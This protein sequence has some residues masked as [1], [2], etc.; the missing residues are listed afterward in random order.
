MFCILTIRIIDFVFSKGDGICQIECYAIETPA[1]IWGLYLYETLTQTHEM[2]RRDPFTYF[3]FPFT[4]CHFQRGQIQIMETALVEF[5][6]FSFATLR[7]WLCC[8]YTNCQNECCFTEL[9]FAPELGNCTL[10]KL[11]NSQCDEVYTLKSLQSSFI[12]VIYLLSSRGVTTR[13][14]TTM[15]LEDLSMSHRIR[16][17]WIWINVNIYKE[18]KRR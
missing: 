8:S 2:K 6:L 1:C 9:C 12:H 5:T 15:I 3:T 10:E 7:L 16:T 13:F 14:V 18:L 4:F 11:G 17:M